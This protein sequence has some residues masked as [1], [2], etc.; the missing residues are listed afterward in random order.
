MDAQWF[1]MDRLYDQYHRRERKTN[2]ND[3]TAST[4]PSSGGMVGGTR[5]AI[6]DWRRSDGIYIQKSTNNQLVN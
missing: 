1:W 5:V 4:A 3:N 2:S 6:R